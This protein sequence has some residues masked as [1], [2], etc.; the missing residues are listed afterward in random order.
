MIHYIFYKGTVSFLVQMKFSITSIKFLNNNQYIDTLQQS[1]ST[2][3]CNPNPSNK[4]T[5]CF[6]E[7]KVFRLKKPPKLWVTF[8]NQCFFNRHWQFTRQERKGRN[9]FL[10][11]SITFP[12]SQTCRYLS[13]TL[14]VRWLPRIFNRTACNYQTTA[15]WDLP[16][17]LIIVWL[18]DD[19]ML[20][21]IC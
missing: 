11:A 20:M 17:Y 1:S 8:F 21:P 15:R 9:I 14:H 18:I 6:T 13:A 16:L 2:V 4:R 7:P 3:N 10:F 12:Y 19:G 5:D